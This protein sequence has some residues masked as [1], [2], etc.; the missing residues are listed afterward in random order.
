MQG[1]CHVLV[2]IRDRSI[3]IVASGFFALSLE[4]QESYTLVTVSP[5]GA[6]VIV[7]AGDNTNPSGFSRD[8]PISPENVETCT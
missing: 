4:V 8:L 1:F 2:A 3:D 5:H 7:A 6:D